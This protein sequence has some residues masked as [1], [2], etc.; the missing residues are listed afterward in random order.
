MTK[1]SDLSRFYRN[2]LERKTT[3]KPTSASIIEKEEQMREAVEKQ[4]KEERKS[5]SNTAQDD[6]DD[7]TLDKADIEIEESHDSGNEESGNEESK[8]DEQTN[9]E[10]SIEEKTDAT[11]TILP[12]PPTVPEAPPQETTEERRKRIFAKRTNEE[13]ALSAKERYLARKKAKMSQPSV[14][15]E[16]D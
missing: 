3:G 10:V 9:K 11:D 13:A 5:E 2:M 14:A 1:E 4:E 16:D 6:E 7:Q 12:A 15:I 8:S